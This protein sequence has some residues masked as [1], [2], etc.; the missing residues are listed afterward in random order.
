MEPIRAPAT[1][2]VRRIR[3]REVSSLELVD[4][5]LARIEAVNPL[6]RAVV[7]TCAEAARAPALLDRWDGLRARLLAWR[8]AT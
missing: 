8:T 5:H 7:T 3:A 2:L 6:L 4:A 1:E